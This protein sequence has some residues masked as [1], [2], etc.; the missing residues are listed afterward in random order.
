MNRYFYAIIFPIFI[1]LLLL[2]IVDVS[3]FLDK[4]TTNRLV[5]RNYILRIAK[6]TIPLKDQ[7]LGKT[8]LDNLIKLKSTRSCQ[9]C[10]LTEANMS[11]LTL[12]EQIYVMQI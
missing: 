5:L 6:I 4:M 8:V 12:V 11:V 9:F 10:N 2:S 1:F 3:R 7:I